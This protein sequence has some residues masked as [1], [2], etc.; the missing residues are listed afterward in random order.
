MHLTVYGKTAVG[1]ARDRNE[2]ALLIADLTNDLRL[3]GHLTRLDV[4]AW[5]AL[6][7]VSD[8]M[9]GAAAGE[10]ASRMVLE[11][12]LR[13][14]SH[15]P[16]TP[17]AVG[18]RSAEAVM[19]LAVNE[20]N[21]EVWQK[22]K[23]EGPGK[24]GA[25][26]AAALVEG[27]FLHLA[28]V[29]DSRAYLLRGGTLTQLSH[30]QSYVQILLDAGAMTTEEA[31]QA[32]MKHVILQAVGHQP[33]VNVALSKLSLRERDCFLLCSDGLSNHVSEEEIRHLIL[34]SSRLDV[35]CDALVD[36]AKTNGGTDDITVVIG[37]VSG[38]LPALVMSEAV[39]ST[40][41]LF[42]EFPPPS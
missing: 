20:A 31:E 13:S 41:E 2:D 7:A 11:S 26:L 3:E 30:D 8:G 16:K 23:E 38:D 19:E 39:T 21:R 29:G 4:G 35:A 36:L 25:T 9:G 42:K 1:P 18:T 6:L 37:G 34:R 14:M 40:L 27:R 15:H 24:M 12:M 5:G 10:V 17:P 22:A 32:P 28:T 33:A